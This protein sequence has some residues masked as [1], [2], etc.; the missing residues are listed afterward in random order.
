M[1]WQDKAVGANGGI[2][3]ALRHWIV[4]SLVVRPELSVV[5]ELRVG[6]CPASI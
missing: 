1:Q 6:K 3:D 2:S 5:E 4:K